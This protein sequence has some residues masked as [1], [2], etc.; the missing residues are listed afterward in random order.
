MICLIR[1]A[2]VMVVGTLPYGM[3]VLHQIL[4]TQ[5]LTLL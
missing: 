3:M 2:G 5:I 1:A 4:T